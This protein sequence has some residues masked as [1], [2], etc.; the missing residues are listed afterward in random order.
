MRATIRAVFGAVVFLSAAGTVFGDGGSL[1]VRKQTGGLVVSV[2]SADSPVRIG[3][4]DFSV[5]VQKASDQSTVMDAN[6]MLRFNTTNQA[7]DV[8]EVVAPATHARAT[9][10]M[11]YAANVT[12]SWPGMW[13]MTAEVTSGGETAGV[14]ADMNVLPH[15]QA[16][17]TYWPYFAVVPFVILLFLF[18]RWLRRRRD[19]L[20]PRARS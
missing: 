15:G 17:Q 5:M 6:V 3:T 2:F 18:N 11:L 8:N 20:I 1:I 7:G 14:T 19:V 10:K 9:N 16:V 12:L 4:T 13:H